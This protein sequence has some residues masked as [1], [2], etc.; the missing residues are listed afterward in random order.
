MTQKALLQKKKWTAENLSHKKD[1][2]TMKC[3]NIKVN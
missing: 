2:K 1:D 3:Y